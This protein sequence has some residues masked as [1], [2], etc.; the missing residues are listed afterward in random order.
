VRARG[1]AVVL[2]IAACRRGPEAPP[3]E[4]RTMPTT[5]TETTAT[6]EVEV[7]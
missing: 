7:P 3:I 4:E 2:L 6:S 1:L 5:T